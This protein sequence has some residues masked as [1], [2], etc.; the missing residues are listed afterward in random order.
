[1]RLSLPGLG[2]LIP[3]LRLTT[4]LLEVPVVLTRESVGEVRALPRLG[5]GPADGSSMLDS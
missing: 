3:L 2:V 4:P 1:M 5:L